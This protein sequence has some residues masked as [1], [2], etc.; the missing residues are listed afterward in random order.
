VHWF[1][2]CN[3]FRLQLIL[4][5]V[6]NDKTFLL[7]D[8]SYLFES[9]KYFSF[10]F[11]NVTAD[12]RCARRNE[13]FRRSRYAKEFVATTIIQWS[14]SRK[15]PSWDSF[16]VALVD[17]RFNL[18]RLNVTDLKFTVVRIDVVNY[19]R[20]WHLESFKKF[21]VL[22]KSEYALLVHRDHRWIRQCINMDNE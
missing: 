3:Q 1:N 4:T 13:F 15:F 8:L 19:D 20:T 14:S 18:R 9:E 12:F 17:F 6:D 10:T 16:F 5:R 2:F 21:L 7:I 22:L 11:A